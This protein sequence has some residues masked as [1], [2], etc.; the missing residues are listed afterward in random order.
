MYFVLSNE[1]ID[2][3]KGERIHA[4]F[5]NLQDKKYKKEKTQHKNISLFPIVSHLSY[6]QK[7]E[8][9]IYVPQKNKIL[10]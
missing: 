6:I 1:D 10:K 2:I 7:Y 9:T 3:I 8:V 4:L 5:A